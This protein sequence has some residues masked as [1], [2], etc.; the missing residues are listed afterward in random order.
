VA[1]DK[2]RF[3]EAHLDA[4]AVA[5]LK[6]E[7]ISKC[8]I[9]KG[10]GREKKVMGDPL[11]A[12]GA[13]VVIKFE[14]CSC[15]KVFDEY[16]SYA[17]MNLPKKYWGFELT[18]ETLDPD[19]RASNPETLGDIIDYSRAL[20]KAR[21]QNIGLYV[22]GARGLGKTA[23]CCWLLKMAS[24]AGYT[25]YFITLQ[26]IVDLAFKAI[27]NEDAEALLQQ[28]TTEIDFLLVDEIDKVYLSR[29][30]EAEAFLDKLMTARYFA[31]KPLLVTSNTTQE[32][33]G[34][35]YGKTLLD[36]FKETLIELTLVG[37]SVRQKLGADL[38]Q[39]LKEK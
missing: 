14:P 37:Q 16:A 18:E 5:V 12:G 15:S 38:R 19:I 28:I 34:T 13:C 9:C 30:G 17:L 32:S 2:S 6:S 1:Y 21:E 11:Q 7:T 27:R 4:G 22:Q 25:G 10:V 36:R 39:Q 3:V 26:E 29:G 24:R 35:V 23:Y 20:P 8:P 31:A 33:L